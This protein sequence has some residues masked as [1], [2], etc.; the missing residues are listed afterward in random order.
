MKKLIASNVQ[1]KTG[2]YIMPPMAEL[3]NG[4]VAPLSSLKAYFPGGYANMNDNSSANEQ[5]RLPNQPS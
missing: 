2:H 5:R 3:K 1:T 4:Y